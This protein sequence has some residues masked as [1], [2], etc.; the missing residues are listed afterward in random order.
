MKKIWI[1][2]NLIALVSGLAYAQY[3]ANEIHAIERE[4]AVIEIELRET[5]QELNSIIEE[6]ERNQDIAE[7]NQE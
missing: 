1:T 4:R 2:L 5:E 7:F 6:I 3:Q